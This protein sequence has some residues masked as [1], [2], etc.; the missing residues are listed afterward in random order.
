MPTKD[1]DLKIEDMMV[2]DESSSPATLA[3][4]NDEAVAAVVRYAE[5]LERNNRTMELLTRTDS[6]AFQ[7]HGTR[8]RPLREFSARIGPHI[9]F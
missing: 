3:N 4:Y 5:E 8:C 9:V 7:P 6:K 1:D 2:D